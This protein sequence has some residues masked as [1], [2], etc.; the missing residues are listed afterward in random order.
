ML[1]RII[2][3]TSAR[4][5][6]HHEITQSGA[7]MSVAVGQVGKQSQLSRVYSAAHFVLE[8]DDNKPV[9]FPRSVEGGGVQAEV[10]THHGGGHIYDMRQ[11]G[12]PK[13]EDLKCQ[14]GMSM[15]EPL[16][17]WIESFFV[18]KVIRKSGAIAAGDFQFVERARRVFSNALISELTFPKLDGADKNP[19]YLTIGL[20]PETIRFAKGSER[21]MPTEIGDVNRQKVWTPANFRFT[22]DDTPLKDACRRVSKVDGFTIK[23]KILEYHGGGLRDSVRAPGILEFPNLTFYVPEADAGPFIDHFTHVVINGK[24]QAPARH[25]GSIVIQDHTHADLCEVKLGGIDIFNVAPDKSDAGSEEIKQ[26]KIEITVESM[27]F[28]YRP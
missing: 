10:M 19:C 18:G 15:T 4:I 26:V 13:Y 27:K 9:G 22:I 17:K 28:N 21:K 16:Y 11:L 12:K 23:Q 1:Q 20:S 3:A 8:L 7:P 14:F 24:G 5:P 2:F 6:V 25:T